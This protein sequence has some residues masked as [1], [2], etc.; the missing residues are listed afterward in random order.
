MAR[1]TAG[2]FT[3]SKVLSTPSFNFAFPGLTLS[4]A[5]FQLSGQFT[6]VGQVMRSKAFVQSLIVAS[7]MSFVLPLLIMGGIVVVLALVAYVPGFATVSQIVT[8]QVLQFLGTFGNGDAIGGAVVISLVFTLVGA[9]FDTY[10]FY[11]RSLL[12]VN[13]GSGRA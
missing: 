12:R 11:Y 10:S 2:T 7:L 9:L 5:L 4:K 1:L 6:Q 13:P 3:F 8:N